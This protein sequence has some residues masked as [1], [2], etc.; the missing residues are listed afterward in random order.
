M[1]I[2]QKIT[3]K[4]LK[5]GANQVE[6][7]I[8]SMETEV[9]QLTD[10]VSQTSDLV[11]QV[12]EPQDHCVHCVECRTRAEIASAK[13]KESIDWAAGLLRGFKKY[14]AAVLRGR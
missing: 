6:T 14:F 3:E 13:A 4:V 1:K 12:P 10:L 9:S 11:S 2:K 5:R 7:F 8:K